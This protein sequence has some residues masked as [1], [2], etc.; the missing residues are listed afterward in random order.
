MMPVFT[1]LTSEQFIFIASLIDFIFTLICFS[2]I[3]IY[4]LPNKLLML[5]PL[6][7]KRTKLTAN[8]ISVPAHKN[9]LNV[10]Y[11]ISSRRQLFSSANNFLWAEA[12]KWR[13]L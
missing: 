4:L 8:G 7:S 11:R 5:L 10:L 3:S 2:F 9:S 6:F 12:D 13:I 1:F